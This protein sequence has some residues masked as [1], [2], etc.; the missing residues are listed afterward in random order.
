MPNRCFSVRG[1]RAAFLEHD[2][3]GSAKALGRHWR[4]FHFFK[5]PKNLDCHERVVDSIEI[6]QRLDQWPMRLRRWRID[7]QNSAQQSQRCLRCAKLAE[8]PTEVKHA[9]K[10]GSTPQLE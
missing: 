6:L 5:L 8:S 1:I 3:Q 2:R 4:L 10:C 9:R 7:V